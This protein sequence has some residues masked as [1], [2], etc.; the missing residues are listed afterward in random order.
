MIRFRLYLSIAYIIFTWTAITKREQDCG[1][2]GKTRYLTLSEA[3]KKLGLSKATLSPIEVGR[4]RPSRSIA[5]R[6]EAHFGEPIT[7]L[8]KSVPKGAVPRLLHADSLE[9]DAIVE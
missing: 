3:A 5:L 1:L 7:Q 2:G 6:L 4:L 9:R 8:L